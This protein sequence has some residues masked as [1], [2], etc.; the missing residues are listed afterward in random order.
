MNTYEVFVSVVKQGSFS[1][2]AKVLHRSPSAICKQM[3]ALEK[4]LD[5]QLFDRTTRNLSITEAGQVYYE[6]C[7]YI[8]QKINDAE[9]EIKS[10]SSES[11]GILRLTW[12]NSLSHSRIV[13]VLRGFSEQY[14]KIN[15]DIENTF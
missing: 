7:K 11:S 15:F 14:P 13:D 2:A 10:L 8:K 1:K 4:K 6:R 5:V 12:S 3:S 9:D